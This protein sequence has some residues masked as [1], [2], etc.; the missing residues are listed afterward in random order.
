[1]I[2]HDSSV[3]GSGRQY[4]HR[5]RGKTETVLIELSSG[6]IGNCCAVCRA[7]RKGRPYVTKREYQQS[8]M[9]APGPEG[10]SWHGNSK[11]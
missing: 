11:K 9:A 6:D 10:E 2:V 8:L 1:M 7:T 3:K 4:C 5:C